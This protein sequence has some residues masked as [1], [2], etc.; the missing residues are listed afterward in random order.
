MA[1]QFCAWQSLIILARGIL[2]QAPLPPLLGLVRFCLDFWLAI[3]DFLG[4]SCRPCFARFAV[5]FGAL[6]TAPGRVRRWDAPAGAENDKEAMNT[7]DRRALS[8]GAPPP[9]HTTTTTTTPLPPTLDT[10]RNKAL[11]VDR[12]VTWVDRVVA[13]ANVQGDFVRRRYAAR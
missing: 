9:P 5:F 6:R 3:L 12:N 11:R 13:G 4:F 8:R 7:S 2:A 1:R 10:Q